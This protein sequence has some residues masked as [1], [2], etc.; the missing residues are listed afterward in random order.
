MQLLTLLRKN[1][2]LWDPR[3]GA[4]LVLLAVALLFS[5]SD[6]FMNFPPAAWGLM[7][8]LMFLL[9]QAGGASALNTDLQHDNILFL[10][11]L[12]IRW[13]WLWLA[14][15]L[16]Q[17]VFNLVFIFFLTWHR[18]LFFKPLSPPA[19]D[20]TDPFS[21]PIL[22]PLYASRW[23][24][25]VALFAFISASFA[26][27][28]FWRTFFRTDKAAIVPNLL[29]GVLFLSWPIAFFTLMHLAPSIADL[30]PI[31]L[32]FTFLFSLASFLAF[33]MP[34][35]YWPRWLRFLTAGLP[36]ITLLFAIEVLVF[37]ASADRWSR[38]DFSEPELRF[39]AATFPDASPNPYTLLT[40][41]SFRSGSHTFYWDPSL[42]SPKYLGREL[43]TT[44]D[45]LNDDNTTTRSTS[46][47]NLA[48]VAEFAPRTLWPT[49]Q[50]LLTMNPDGSSP[51]Q[52]IHLDNLAS[53]VIENGYF[54]GRVR[55]SADGSFY[56]VLVEPPRVSRDGSRLPR[57][58]E[59]ILLA[60][61]SATGAVRKLSLPARS[62]RFLEP[63]FPP[64][65]S[66]RRSSLRHPIFLHPSR[67]RSL[68]LP[69]PHR[70][71]LPSHHPALEHRSRPRR[72][73]Q[74]KCAHRHR[75]FPPQRPAPRP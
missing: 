72:A 37:F 44:D 19:V 49:G 65:L 8:V 57:S 59:N 27:T 62:R 30:V 16:D 34:P 32:L 20:V 2:W 64:P 38:L 28:L 68:P 60:V 13:S 6:F 24:L 71:P 74:G 61:D 25:P 42:D 11:Y 10:E 73:S 36:L 75:G 3:K 58:R 70:M 31:L 18:L 55:R 22:S 47:R 40:V 51:H 9:G 15:Y 66:P 12:P 56:L 7:L 52:L 45:E 50:V 46:A 67:T 69:R 5:I 29:A 17:F 26:Y 4:N 35:R 21:D 54:S 1:F 23:L 33:A 41:R 48:F 43:S 53:S 14:N 39:N 63:K